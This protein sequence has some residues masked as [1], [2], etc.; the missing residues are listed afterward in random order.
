MSGILGIENRTENWRTTVYF[1]P[2]F[3]EKSY[4]FAE[5]LGATPAFS[6]AA[7]RIELFWK[8]I[9]DY[10]HREGISRKDLER[11][12]VE[13]YDRNFSNLREDVLGFQEFAK[14][15]R[16]HYVSDGEGAESR[17]TNNLL[18]TEIDVVLETP[19]HLFIG[20]VKHESTFGAD[21]KL[22]LV[23]QLV[24][25]Y[26]TATILLQI[27]GENKEVI[28]FVV[29]DSTDYLK[30][31][32]QVRFMISQGWLSQANVLDWGDVKRAQVL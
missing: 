18:G 20:E 17:L 22:V 3:S 7:V 4:K 29:G 2:M 10:R 26:V 6:P 25:Q 5:V 15:E 23:H 28:P 30:K 9:R 12:V 11:K 14:L 32:S 24:R 16:G 8:G 19:K 31:T 13:A 1:S 21:G 27:A